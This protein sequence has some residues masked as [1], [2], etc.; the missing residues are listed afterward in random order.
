MLQE[1]LNSDWGVHD[2]DSL[3]FVAFRRFPGLQAKVL[4]H[5]ALNS[6]EHFH[7]KTEFGDPSR[8][9]RPLQ[10]VADFDDTLQANWLDRRVPRRS[11]YPG[12]M[13]FL[14]ELRLTSPA[15][16]AEVESTGSNMSGAAGDSGA[17]ITSWPQILAQQATVLEQNT[18][19][20]GAEHGADGNLID[21]GRH[22][23][24]RL[25]QRWRHHELPTD[26]AP[27]GAASPTHT[28][29]E[30][31]G[32]SDSDDDSDGESDTA[33][34]H[35]HKQDTSPSSMGRR[36]LHSAQVA[37]AVERCIP[38]GSVAPSSCAPEHLPLGGLLVLTAR[39]AGIR[40]FVKSR[41]QGH[42]SALGLEPVSV[43]TGGVMH[44]ATGRAIAEKKLQNLEKFLALFPEMD[45]TL[46]GDAGQ[47]DAAFFLGAMEQHGDR[48]RSAFVHNVTPDKSHTGDGGCK[49]A[50]KDAG[51]QFFGTYVG[52]AAAALHSGA[53]PQAAA[54]RVGAAAV[55]ECS[56]LCEGTSVHPLH[57]S[58]H[59][60]M[61]QAGYPQHLPSAQSL[62]SEAPAVPNGKLRTSVRRARWQQR[63]QRY[64][65]SMQ[66]D[67]QTLSTCIQAAAPQ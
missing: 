28:A 48:I 19:A 12:A 40:N 13:Q 26:A 21:R 1:V 58:I 25:K 60:I 65:D 22:H 50:Y 18:A 37:R 47:A 53:L 52:A 34:I 56:M 16:A 54:V 61:A 11:V 27:G 39:P 9:A 42:L 5:F 24:R 35:P 43:L 29:A 31:R 49:Q 41:T 6:A 8:C 67:L 15:D 45:V 59:N 51:I 63:L 57:D 64:T 14:R 38:L 46:L 62:V 55:L 4:Q 32:E 20:A 23:W 66:Q 44:L 17:R 3:L 36:A 2:L 33:W 10:V 7:R 30:L